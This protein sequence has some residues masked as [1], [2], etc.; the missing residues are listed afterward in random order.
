MNLIT[1]RLDPDCLLG[2]CG[3]FYVRTL[4]YGTSF[5]VAPRKG[6]DRWAHYSDVS[7]YQAAEIL[8]INVNDL[9]IWAA[10]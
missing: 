1:T 4:D 2:I 7:N 6:F 3:G 5:R 8:G 10:Q 9:A